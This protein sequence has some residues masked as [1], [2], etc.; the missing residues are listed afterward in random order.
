MATNDWIT[1]IAR[2]PIK[3]A[4]SKSKITNWIGVTKTNS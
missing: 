1:T 4:Y 2:K 3:S